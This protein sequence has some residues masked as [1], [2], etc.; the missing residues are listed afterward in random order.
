MSHQFK[1]GDSALVIGGNAF[2]GSQVEIS[3]RLNPGSEFDHQGSQYKYTPKTGRSG[4]MV[5]C[6]EQWGVKHESQLMPLRGD[7]TPEQQKAKEV[8]A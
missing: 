2:L 5:I 6:G 4:W 3:R 1:P 8:V 7:F